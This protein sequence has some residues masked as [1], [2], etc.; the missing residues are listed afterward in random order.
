[1]VVAVAVEVHALLNPPFFAEPEPEPVPRSSSLPP[2]ELG[3]SVA[4]DPA[5]PLLPL[6]PLPLVPAGLLVGK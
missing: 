3:F 2:P 5:A 6:P 4:P 1:M